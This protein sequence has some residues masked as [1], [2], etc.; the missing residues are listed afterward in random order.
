MLWQKKK[1]KKFHLCCSKI[2]RE[3]R[4]CFLLWVSLKK[5]QGSHDQQTKWPV[6][7]SYHFKTNQNFITQTSH[8]SPNSA[9]SHEILITI[10]FIWTISN[11]LSSWIMPWHC[12]L[13]TQDGSFGWR[14]MAC[15]PPDFWLHWLVG[16]KCS[17]GT[18]YDGF[19]DLFALLFFLN[20]F[21][22]LNIIIACMYRFRLLCYQLK[23]AI[24]IENGAEKS[25]H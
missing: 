9:K 23:T 13:C 18:S 7:K 25:Y 4:C 1:K 17:A 22:E 6:S 11:Q 14:T 20:M 10:Y 12:K 19:F 5:S 8:A 24:K 2:Q 3:D 15:F 16:G 21:K